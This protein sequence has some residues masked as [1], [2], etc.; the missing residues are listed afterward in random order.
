[1]SRC[2]R[3]LRRLS[4]RSPELAQAPPSVSFSS[5][6]CLC[7]SRAV[8]VWRSPAGSLPAGVATDMPRRLS[9][10][11]PRRCWWAGTGRGVLGF[12]MASCHGVGLV[13]VPRCWSVLHG[14]VL[15]AWPCCSLP[16]CLC[17][18]RRCSW[19]VRAWVE[20]RGCGFP[21]G[22]GVGLTMSAVL[23]G[24]CPLLLLSRPWPVVCVCV[25]RR[26]GC[27]GA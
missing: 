13:W 8:C 23:L 24:E 19:V 14:G 15:G 3:Y 9:G 7:S 27:P 2:S 5:S 25:W 20:P 17:R 10:E 18:L 16:P 6:G 11:R 4:G 21:R 22:P 12:T 26:S 1:M